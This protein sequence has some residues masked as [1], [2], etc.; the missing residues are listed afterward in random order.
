[1]DDIRET[2]EVDPRIVRF[3]R[4]HHLL[5][6]ATTDAEAPYCAHAFY[7]YDAERNLLIFASDDTTHHVQQMERRPKV[8]AAIASPTRIVG[9]LQ[10]LQLCGTATRADDKARKTYIRRFPFA[11]L[12]ELRLWVIKPNYMKYTDNTLGFGTKLIWNA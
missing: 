7:G 8:S 2:P 6:L 12:M 3:V 11:A 9:K 10:G 1:M 4:R 5:T